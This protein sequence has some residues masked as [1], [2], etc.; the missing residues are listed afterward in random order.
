[1]PV[2]VY[3]VVFVCRWLLFVVVGVGGCVFVGCSLSIVCCLLYDVCSLTSHVCFW[4]RVRCC[5]L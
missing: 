5:L 4:L 3:L 1:M 2:V